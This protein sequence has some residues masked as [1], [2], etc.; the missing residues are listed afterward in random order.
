MKLR[1]GLETRVDWLEFTIKDNENP[2][3]VIEMIGYEPA[4]FDF[5][6]RGCQGYKKTA[7]HCVDSVIVMYDGNENM[8]VHVRISG[9]AVDSFLNNYFEK[10]ILYNADRQSVRKD[11][12]TTAFNDLC[13]IVSAHGQFTR[14]DLAIDDFTKDFFT[15]DEL[16]SLCDNG[17][18]VSKFRTRNRNDKK[19]ISENEKIG[20]TIYFGSRQ[21]D[22]FLR[23]YDKF[24]EQTE[25]ENDPECD[26]W[27]RWELEIKGLKAD[28]VANQLAERNVDE[29]T[30]VVGILSNY[31]RFI[32][33]DDSN[34]SRC[35]VLDKWQKF[36]DGIE[37]LRIVIGKILHTVDRK[38]DWIKRQCLPT[39]AGL[40]KYNGGDM[41]F[42]YNNLEESYER[43]KPKL[44]K[45]YEG[46][47]SYV[48]S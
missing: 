40:V 6:D 17:Q 48:L 1:N 18:C 24:L 38:L 36:I 21:S 37:K 9:S 29:G 32:K 20:D 35:T 47:V 46:D 5:T 28:Y 31:I 11:C 25:K 7:R 44:R 27:M 39:I 23:V 13:D 12:W 41:S 30:I 4:D 19:K 22:V 2:F 10:R 3:Q 34:R 16:W 33:I 14:L 42:M 15:C 26:S 8:G 43:N 45:L